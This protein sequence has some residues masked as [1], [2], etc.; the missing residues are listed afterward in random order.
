MT[1][2]TLHRRL[3]QF[4]KGIEPFATFTSSDA[5]RLIEQHGL[6]MCMCRDRLTFEAYFQAVYGEKLET[7]VKGRAA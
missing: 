3:S 2:S 7:K 4:C 5:R 6:T 1:A